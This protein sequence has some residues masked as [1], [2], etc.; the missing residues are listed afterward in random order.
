MVESQRLRGG[1][2][3]SNSQALINCKPLVNRHSQF[4]DQRAHHIGAGGFVESDTGG[5]MNS[6]IHFTIE[7]N[8]AENELAPGGGGE[9]GGSS[10]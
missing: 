6:S 7:D 8:S 1:L 3:H 4:A 9:G 5:E 2:R 10:S